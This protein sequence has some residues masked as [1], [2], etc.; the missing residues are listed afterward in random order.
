MAIED[1]FVGIRVDL[2]KKIPN[3]SFDIKSS[4]CG[5]IFYDNWRGSCVVVV[6]EDGLSNANSSGSHVS[7]LACGATSPSLNKASSYF[8]EAILLE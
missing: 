2:R 5:Y 7:V 1:L 3:F 4:Q 6:I 8:G